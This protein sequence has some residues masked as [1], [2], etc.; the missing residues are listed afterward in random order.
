MNVPNRL[1]YIIQS[2]K[3][4]FSLLSE[5]RN[6]LQSLTLPL[7]LW[8]K[9]RKNLIQLLK[10]KSP[11]R[12]YLLNFI[13]WNF[14]YLP[15]FFLSQKWCLISNKCTCFALKDPFEVSDL[16]LRWFYHCLLF[17]CTVGDSFLLIWREWTSFSR[18]AGLSTNA[19]MITFFL[20]YRRENT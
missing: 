17:S 5:H 14:S 3:E 4:T 15:I 2:F 20:I 19:G 18:C 12:R 9:C 10:I 16:T 1:N 11:F 7:L 13:S 6:P 8:L